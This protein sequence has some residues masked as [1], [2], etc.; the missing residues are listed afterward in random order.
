M[1]EVLKKG[2]IKR[3][4]SGASVNIWQDNWIPEIHGFKPRVRLSGVTVNTVD[5]LF[6]GDTRHWDFYRVHQSFISIDAEC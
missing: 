2:V 5:E 1:G 3:V 4:G 6:E